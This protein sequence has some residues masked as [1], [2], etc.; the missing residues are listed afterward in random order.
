MTSNEF[1]INDRIV[2]NKKLFADVNSLEGILESRDKEILRNR[3]EIE[4]LQDANARLI[5]ENNNLKGKVKY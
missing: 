5:A 4:D 3:V 1:I 2:L